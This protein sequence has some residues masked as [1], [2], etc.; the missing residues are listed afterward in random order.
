MKE[1]DGNWGCKC[2]KYSPKIRLTTPEGFLAWWVGHAPVGQQ[3]P[4]VAKI[5]S[6][7]RRAGITVEALSGFIQNLL[8]E[9]TSRLQLPVEAGSGLE[10][11]AQGLNLPV[12]SLG[13][14]RVVLATDPELC[15]KETHPAEA[16]V[17][18]LRNFIGQLAEATECSQFA[19]SAG[20]PGEVLW[21]KGT[22][23]LPAIVEHC[24][25][26]A[27][28]HLHRSRMSIAC[29]GLS[30][31]VWMKDGDL[32]FVKVAG[33]K[34]GYPKGLLLNTMFTVHPCTE[35]DMVAVT[36]EAAGAASWVDRQR[37]R[38]APGTKILVNDGDLIVPGTILAQSRDREFRFK[39]ED[40]DSSHHVVRIHG[41]VEDGLAKGRVVIEILTPMRG[42]EGMKVMDRHSM[43]GLVTYLPGKWFAEV[44]GELVPIDCLANPERVVGPKWK[45]ASCLVEAKASQDGMAAGLSEVEVPIT[46][47]FTGDVADLVVPLYYQGEGDDAPFQLGEGIFSR[48][49]WLVQPQTPEMLTGNPPVSD[50][51]FEALEEDGGYHLQQND[52]SAGCRKWS[53]TRGYLEANC[54]EIAEFC[55]PPAGEAVKDITAH[56]VRT[57]LIK[58]KDVMD[59]EGRA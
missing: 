8:W 41:D 33:N 10:Q 30:N 34:T 17:A 18:T 26:G 44:D 3:D 4:P 13:K 25:P 56:L 49:F 20:R 37:T 35:L 5:I 12:E 43:K 22:T 27:L 46:A 50:S 28:R 23:S 42:G 9:A 14:V 32:P 15:N 19:S 1:K 40:F 38:V 2:G 6:V 21:K 59:M 45:C 48:H 58:D 24:T 39:C 52:A 55:Y 16:R 11:I 36:P 57:L 29:S 47:S 7:S 31:A 53:T 54:G 51:S